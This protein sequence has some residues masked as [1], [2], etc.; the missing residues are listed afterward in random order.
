M[1]LA[2]LLLVVA[3]ACTAWTQVIADAVLVGMS[4]GHEQVRGGRVA[5]GR[6]GAVSM[7]VG[8]CVQGA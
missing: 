4:Q 1:A 7:W 8:S 6:A 3:N 5:G 2:A